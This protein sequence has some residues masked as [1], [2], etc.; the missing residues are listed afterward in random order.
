MA[1]FNGLSVCYCCSTMHA[2]YFY[3]LLGT[4]YTGTLSVI[5][6]QTWSM[7]CIL[8]SQLLGIVQYGG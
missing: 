3:L 6:I 7:P 5:P 4:I 1:E 2:Y 8:G